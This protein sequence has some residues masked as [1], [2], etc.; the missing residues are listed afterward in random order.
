MNASVR[1]IYFV[2]KSSQVCTMRLCVFSF[3]VATKI[4]ARNI[5]SA[6]DSGLGLESHTNTGCFATWKIY[7]I[8]TINC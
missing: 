1:S 8:V 5:T 3:G 4:L 7:I 2:R 6:A